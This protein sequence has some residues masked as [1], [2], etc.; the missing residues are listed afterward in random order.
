LGFDIYVEVNGVREVTTLLNSPE[1]WKRSTYGYQLE[2]VLRVMKGETE[3]LTGGEDAV[4]TMTAI[5]AIM[6]AG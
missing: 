2:H 1:S 3:P 5:D 6:A 4:A